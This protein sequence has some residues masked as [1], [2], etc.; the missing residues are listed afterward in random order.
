MSVI[1]SR[2]NSKHHQLQTIAARRQRI[3]PVVELLY[4]DG[5]ETGAAR[6]QACAYLGSEP[7]LFTLQA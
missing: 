4:L 7:W 2:V 1:S 6:L 3:E 5:I